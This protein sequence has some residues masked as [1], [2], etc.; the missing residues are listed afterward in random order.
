MDAFI[1]QLNN[2]EKLFLAF[3]AFFVINY[4]VIKIWEG[5]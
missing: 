3:V 5:A 1:Q 4:L 2:E